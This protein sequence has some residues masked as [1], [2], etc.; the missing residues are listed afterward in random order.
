VEGAEGVENS[1]SALS[2]SYIQVQLK[3]AIK[4][5]LEITRYFYRG[6]LNFYCHDNSYRNENGNDAATRTVSLFPMY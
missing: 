2:S 4:V 6:K 3:E 1:S 5:P